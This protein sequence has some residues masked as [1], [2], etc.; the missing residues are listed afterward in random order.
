MTELFPAGL[1]HV[2]R[3]WGEEL[4]QWLHLGAVH[5][6]LAG[7]H[8]VDVFHHRRDRR[9]VA[10]CRQVVADLPDGRVQLAQHRGVR[11]TVGRAFV[12]R[13]PDAIQE[14]AHAG[15][16]AVA[17]IAAF[18]VGAEE[19]EV[20]A[21]A[22][23]APAVDEVVRVHH[24]ALRLRHLRA[25]ANDHAVGSEAR[26]RLLEV[27]QARVLQRHRDEAGV[28]QVQHRVLVAADVGGDRQPLPRERGVERHV[29]A[30]GAWVTQEIPGAVQEGVA[31][32]G[33][34]TCHD[35]ARRAGHAI[36]L[37]MT[38]E[39]RD[40]AV[41]GTEIVDQGQHDGQLVFGYRH[42][43]AA[44]TVD[45]R[46]WRTPVALP[47]DAPVVEAVVHDRRGTAALLEPRDHRLLRLR[48]RHAR[49]M[50]RVHQQVGVALRRVRLGERRVC[51]VVGTGDHAHDGQGKLLR[52]LE[53]ALVV[54]RYAHH[55]T[56]AV[57]HQHVVGDPDRDRLT[58]G[59]VDGDGAGEDAGLLL[60]HLPR[61]DVLR[62]GALQVGVDRGAPG[63]RDDLRHQ[64]MLGGEH[65]PCGAEDRV[66]AR[67]E[68]RD[69]V[70]VRDAEGDVRAVAATD[71]VPLRLTRGLAPVQRRDVVQQARCV[72]R[73]AEEPLF[74]QALLD[75][76]VTAFALS[77]LHLLVGQYGLAAGAPVHR[78]GLLVGQSLLVELQEEPLRPLV[79]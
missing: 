18:L 17:V 57:F 32:V 69:V 19:H 40:A 34:A 20:R 44:V 43:A 70:R 1:G 65:D 26:E 2:R 25:V 30:I 13:A 14:A 66:G 77:I 54:T 72:L 75:E 68:H 76:R 74:Q 27:E 79:V 4:Q 22:V 11:R 56:G 73:R 6:A 45:D 3:E 47:R 51:V 24:V 21:K 35:A 5:R 36:P 52:E 67:G 28:E 31:D 42:R 55:G 63:G 37:V 9:V 15:D 33:L 39:R 78:G 71:P 50:T 16:A 12:H 59:R 64:R 8:R 60:V 49:E 46:D 41:V 48:N 62:P 7:A 53:I 58:R 29:G 38:R 61:D 10:Q 23:G